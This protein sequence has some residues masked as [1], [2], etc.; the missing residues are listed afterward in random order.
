MKIWLILADFEA[1]IEIHRALKDAKEN[2][3]VCN[4]AGNVLNIPKFYSFF[5]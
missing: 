1:R 4:A 3:G 5:N 2:T